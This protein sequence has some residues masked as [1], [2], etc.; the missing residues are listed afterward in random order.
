MK[1]NAKA[2]LRN[3]ECPV[4]EGVYHILPE[5]TLRRI[6]PA[7]YFIDTILPKERVHVLLPEKELIAQIFSRD[8]IL[9]VIWKDQVQHSAIEKQMQEV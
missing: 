5:W 2:Y 6:L 8:Q 7:V 1:I 9:I 3:R 4:H